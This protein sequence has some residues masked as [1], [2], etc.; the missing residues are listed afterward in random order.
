MRGSARTAELRCVP[1]RIAHRA[2]YWI[3]A[4]FAAMML[5]LGTATMLGG[6]P[7]RSSLLRSLQQPA[8]S[9]A[10]SV[11]QLSRAVRVRD[12]TL[13]LQMAPNRAAASNRLTVRLTDGARPVTGSRVTVSFSMPSMNMWDAYSSPLRRTGRGLYSATVPVLGMPGLWRL[14][15]HVARPGSRALDVAVDDPIGS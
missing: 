3:P 15:V 6:R 9:A 2:R 1:L 11:G 4:A 5:M 14:S 8:R 10:T 12:Y 13:A 7:T